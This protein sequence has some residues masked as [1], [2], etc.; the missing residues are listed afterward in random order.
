MMQVLLLAAAIGAAAPAPQPDEVVAVVEV[1][2]VLNPEQLVPCGGEF[3]IGVFEVTVVRVEAGAVPAGA[4][5]LTVEVGCPVESNVGPGFRYR[6]RLRTRRPPLWTMRLPVPAGGV[7][8]YA[9]GI[10]PVCDGPIVHLDAILR[11]RNC[12]VSREK[13]LTDAGVVDQLAV[14]IEPERATATAGRAFTLKLAFENTAAGALPLTLDVF[15]RRRSFG[16]EARGDGAGDPGGPL[17]CQGP[18]H[19]VSFNGSAGERQTP[20]AV[21]AIELAPG[22]RLVTHLLC[23]VDRLAGK[24]MARGSYKLRVRTPLPDRATG[25]DRFAEAGLTVD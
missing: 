14:R 8:F 20:A 6:A 25:G 19:G 11:S 17:R 2:R 10:E 18:T 5:R 9:S 1:A 16:V 24:P 13:R 3:S 12:R 23:R 22:G 4:S 15:D 7:H 21:L